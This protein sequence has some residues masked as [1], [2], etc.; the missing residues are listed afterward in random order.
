MRYSSID[1]IYNPNST[2]DSEHLAR[3]LKLSLKDHFDNIKINLVKTK[4]AGHAEKLA[5]EIAHSTSNPLV[6]SSSGDGGYNEVINGIIRS[7]GEGASPI[8]AVLPAGNANDHS[9]TLHKQDITSAI[10]SGKVQKLDLLRAKYSSAG[11]SKI[12][13]AHSYIGL[14]LTPVV[15]TELNKA[16]LNA[17]REL[18][19]TVKTFYKF[20]P[21]K[22]EHHGTKHTLDSILFS[23]IGEMAKVLTLSK[24]SSPKDGKFEVITFPHS[25]KF[26]LLS[27]IVTAAL[28]GLKQT[29]H[30]KT[31]KI[32][33]LKRMPMQ[34]DGEVQIIDKNSELQITSERQVLRTII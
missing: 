33:I 22:I 13:Y 15:A 4:Y 11:K 34:L 26:M 21:F 28:T 8:C 5:Y 17:F 24:N 9:R 6:I 20:R 18:C 12:R 19:L 29:K 27:K 10:I 1:I 2:G 32:K 31:Y 7:Q 14:G 23:N 3:E 30:Y 25:H 16:D